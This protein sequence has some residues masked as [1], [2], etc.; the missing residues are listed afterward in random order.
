MTHSLGFGHLHGR[1]SNLNPGSAD[2]PKLD[3]TLRRLGHINAP[4]LPL[5]GLDDH[6]AGLIDDAAPTSTD[7][8]T[9]WPAFTGAT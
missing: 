6:W 4:D 1:H 8:S 3:D 5:R 9:A 2:L 7:R